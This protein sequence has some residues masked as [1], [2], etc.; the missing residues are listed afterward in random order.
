M[1][2]WVCEIAYD[3]TSGP[4]K[5]LESFY[6]PT[7]EDVRA[8]VTK[9][10]DMYCPFVTRTLSAKGFWPGLA[11]GRFNC[12]AGLCFSSMAASLVL[13]WKIIQAETNPK[14]Q[15]ILAPA[16]EALARGLGVIDALKALN[17]FDSGTLAILAASERV[18][19]F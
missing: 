18:T 1:K 16:R 3:S 6:L 2:Q 5:A 14:R 12:F 19:A 15:N 17:I 7:E 11:G 8:A 4:K 10:V 13:L 9:R